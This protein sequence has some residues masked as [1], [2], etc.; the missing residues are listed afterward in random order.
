MPRK[1]DFK[2]LPEREANRY[3]QRLGEFCDLLDRQGYHRQ[4]TGT[5]RRFSLRF[6][7]FAVK[8]GIRASALRDDKIDGLIQT[9]VGL[10]KDS[11]ETYAVHCLKRFVD[12]LIQVG[13]APV[14]PRK[15]DN[16]KRSV[17]M[18]G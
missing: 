11:R 3:I 18:R 8:R 14:R 12:F 16:S 15:V 17:L 6:V 2:P 9:V 13:D 10:H 5:Y 7:E 4:T 1:R